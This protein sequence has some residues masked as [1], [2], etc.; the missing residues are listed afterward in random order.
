MR[1][2]TRQQLWVTIFAVLASATAWN[3]IAGH[4]SPSR[5][6]GARW[7][8]TAYQSPPAS[9][10][11]VGTAD[12]LLGDGRA[13]PIESG[14]PVDDVYG[15]LGSQNVTLVPMFPEGMF[16]PVLEIRLPDSPV[17]PS[18]VAD[19]DRS[20]CGHFAVTRMSVL[21][22]RFRTK[23]GLGV[24]TTEA[25]LRRR[26]SFTISEEEGCHC[27]FIESLNL[28]FSFDAQPVEKV[29][30]VWVVD[31]PVAI[32]AK[33]CPNSITPWLGRQ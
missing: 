2:T 31:D 12:F 4:L 28:S 10:I 20:P 3:L 24:G 26:F 22:P 18:I 7:P 15:L 29:S 32:H 25:E 30:S 11:Q 8:A 16:Q 13:G 6:R 23:D 21:D 33:R 9:G 5:P 17:Q 14:M 27:A 1:L 19:I